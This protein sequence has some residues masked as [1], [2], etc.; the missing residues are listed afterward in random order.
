MSGLVYRAQPRLFL[1]VALVSLFLPDKSGADLFNDVVSANSEALKD[2][3]AK[4]GTQLREPWC[5][6]LETCNQSPC[7]YGSCAGIFTDPKKTTC[8]SGLIPQENC[9]RNKEDE[10]YQL[11]SYQ[12]KCSAS[13][14]PSG[15]QIG[16]DSPNIRVHK[17]YLS[18]QGIEGTQLNV[19]NIAAKRDLCALRPIQDEFEKNFEGVSHFYYV[20]T[21]NK[22]FFKYPS[23]ASCRHEKDAN[24]NPFD[25]CSSYDPTIRP[26]YITAAS[27]PRDVVF[28]VDKTLRKFPNSNLTKQLSEAS[29]TK[30]TLFNYFDIRD[31][32]SVVLY[33]QNSADVLA[34]DDDVLTKVKEQDYLSRVERDFNDALEE[35]SAS[36]KVGIKKAFDVFVKSRAQERTSGCGNNYIIVLQSSRDSCFDSCS[37]SSGTCKCVQETIDLV[38]EQ[39]KRLN[40]PASILF[41]SEYQDDGVES[42]K[43]MRQGDFERLA[44]TL[45]CDENFG[46][47][48]KFNESSDPSLPAFGQHA[49]LSLR[50][51]E[52]DTTYSSGLYDDFSG[53]G[54]M[55]TLARPIYGQAGL[56]GVAGVDIRVS[57]VTD[58]NR[59]DPESYAIQRIN[60]YS[61]TSRGC[62]RVVTKDG[63][64]YQRLRQQY[65]RNC[66]AIPPK[67]SDC[68][69]FG[70]FVYF[71]SQRRLNFEDSKSLC[72]SRGNTVPV[73]FPSP[74][75]GFSQMT[76]IDSAERNTRLSGIFNSDGSWIGIRAR[77]RGSIEFADGTP[78]GDTQFI[79]DQFDFPIEEEIE[80]LQ[81]KFNQDVC[82]IADRRAVDHNWNFVPC[83][84][85]H[86]AICSISESASNSMCS[87]VYDM[88]RL[89]EGTVSNPLDCGP[90][91][92]CSSEQDEFEKRAKPICVQEGVDLTDRER[93]CCNSES[94]TVTDPPSSPVGNEPVDDGGPGP[95]L[96][97]II[98]GAVGGVV[99][100]II[101]VILYIV[102]RN[103][104]KRQN[105]DL[106]ITQDKPTQE[107]N[108]GP[109]VVGVST[110]NNGEPVPEVGT[111]ST[112]GGRN[113]DDLGSSTVG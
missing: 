42:E 38:N 71:K 112:T 82:I 43:N 104:G 11:S 103:K 111:I 47:W 50:D 22:V 79:Q 67:S 44:G 29:S 30:T 83:S 2:L 35:D 17:S 107:N 106:P 14:N 24:D 25:Q 84:R 5:S 101:A 3:A 93:S 31:Y 70:D 64:D 18:S 33:G 56:L 40:K 34:S 28:L 97:P 92:P 78:V 8:A 72:E 96:A 19:T 90:Y 94:P 80:R 75:P 105:G 87:N 45:A 61:S 86:M 68:Y 54:Q 63:C 113:F 21:R 91:K 9:A 53:Y 58:N 10:A 52:S 76:V 98:G 110:G 12:D 99:L 109:A 15:L 59:P 55:F 23:V 89:S 37:S 48:Q 95:D 65:G 102:Y 16:Y 26:W 39:Q 4:V 6:S 60:D 73:I 74:T 69:K 85:S 66:P 20:G 49:A 13:E 88:E 1:I 108:S 36:I 27:G 41:F 7:F 46:L 77:F 51:D 81:N 100:I 62:P 32:M 57:S